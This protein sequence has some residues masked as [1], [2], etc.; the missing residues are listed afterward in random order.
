MNIEEKGKAFVEEIEIDVSQQIEIF[1][2]PSHNDVEAAHYYHD[3]KKVS[4]SVKLYN[5]ALQ[6]LVI[7][8]ITVY[9][10]DE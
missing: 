2:V 10:P 1:R 7:E 8:H 6:I 3:F 4:V 5:R 9:L